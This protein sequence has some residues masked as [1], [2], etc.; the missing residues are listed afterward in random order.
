[1]ASDSATSIPSQQS[2]KA[3][4]DTTVG[5]VDLTVSTMGDS[6]TGSVSTSQTLTISGT[7]NEVETSASNQS[8]T[9]GLPI[10]SLFLIT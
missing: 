1:M 10:M 6:G 2:V 9:I 7:S 5:A 8:I 4:V 3:Y